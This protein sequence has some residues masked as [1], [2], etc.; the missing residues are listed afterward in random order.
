MPFW[1]V[2]LYIS[3]CKV[4]PNTC[5]SSS[6]GISGFAQYAGL[7]ENYGAWCCPLTLFHAWLLPRAHL[8]TYM[9]GPIC[10]LILTKTNICVANNT[11]I[12]KR[13][14]P[15]PC[16]IPGVAYTKSISCNAEGHARYRNI[17]LASP[18]KE[19]KWKQPSKFRTLV[20]TRV[21]GGRGKSLP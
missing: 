7:G 2:K 18:T 16:H 9:N 13:K 20:T 12:V 15:F 10:T 1:L 17:L 5:I 21:G 14:S 19:L 6:I 8:N 4:T 11:I 3:T